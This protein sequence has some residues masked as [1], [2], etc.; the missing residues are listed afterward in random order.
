MS[1]TAEIA[2]W[3]NVR[4]TIA[5]WWHTLLV[6]AL[7][8]GLSVV[9]HR[10]GALPDAH[11]P[12][13]NARLSSYITT[14]AAEWLL[15]AFIWSGIR[16]RG[17]KIGSLISGRW[18]SPLAFFRD[19]GLALSVFVV[20]GLPLSLLASRFA[21]H[22]SSA[23]MAILPKTVPELAVWFALSA[24][25]G[26]CEELIFRGYLTIQF[27]AW[28]G[29]RAAAVVLQALAFGLG[30]GYYRIGVMVVIAIL[31]FCLGLLTL[32]RK[33]LRPA[34]LFHVLQDAL[35]GIEGFLSRT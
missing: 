11:L 34:M 14:L 23:Q 1:S 22:A 6:L 32:W 10:Q 18:P 25:A 2:P 21:G 24:T 26:F 16:L 28:T 8:G 7:I 4:Q 30:H 35:G 20:V 9:S 31:G 27:S 33:T 17:M 12:G 13:L 3:V 15:I 29:S 5:P 19:L